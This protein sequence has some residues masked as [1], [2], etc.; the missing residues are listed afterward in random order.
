MLLRVTTLLSRSIE[1]VRIF[2]TLPPETVPE[3]LETLEWKGSVGD[4]EN[5]IASLGPTAGLARL[6]FDVDTTISERM[7]VEFMPHQPR[8]WHDH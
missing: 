1:G 7:G 8:E 4:I 5:L 3:Y 2:V 6:Q